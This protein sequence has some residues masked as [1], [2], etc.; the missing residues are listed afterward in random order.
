MQGF[1]LIGSRKRLSLLAVVRSNR[2]A[3][4]LERSREALALYVQGEIASDGDSMD[5]EKAESHFAQ[6]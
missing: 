2:P 1:L 6:P 5:L 4:S 3:A